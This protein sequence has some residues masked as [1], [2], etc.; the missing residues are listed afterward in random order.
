MGQL[1]L[2]SGVSLLCNEKANIGDKSFSYLPLSCM[3]GCRIMLQIILSR[4]LVC[5]AEGRAIHTPVYGLIKAI[6]DILYTS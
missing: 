6:N 1:C 4:L 5:L 2:W 3:V